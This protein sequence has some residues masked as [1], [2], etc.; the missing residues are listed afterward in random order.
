MEPLTYIDRGK[1][2]GMTVDGFSIWQRW[3]AGFRRFSDE[4]PTVNLK[5]L[6]S[7][8]SDSGPETTVKKVT[9]S[10][11]IIENQVHPSIAEVNPQHPT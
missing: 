5:D 1:R 4:D 10:S 8:D 2:K 3:W 9:N 7:S 6:E 11:G